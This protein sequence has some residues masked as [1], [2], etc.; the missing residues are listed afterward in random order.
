MTEAIQT[1]EAKTQKPVAAK[2]P[3]QADVAKYFGRIDIGAD[4]RPT[5][6]WES[7]ALTQIALPYPLRLS[8][9]T[10][11]TVHRLTCHQAIA[12]D[13]NSIFGEIK[14]L[15]SEDIQKIR[16]ARMDLYGG[17]YN[18]RPM[19]G[20]SQLSMHSYGI[21]IDL[22]PDG[23]PFHKPWKHD[24]GM[25]PGEVVDI[26]LAHGWTWGGLWKSSPDPMHFQA[27]QPL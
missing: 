24:A 15:Y 17:C 22:D 3:R 5:D 16:A 7:N 1:P 12:R 27:T 18:F 25:M 20:G 26:F 10:D 6:R 8:W 2:Y 9:D 23:N 21:A 19:R 11:V 4:G 14:R 13:L